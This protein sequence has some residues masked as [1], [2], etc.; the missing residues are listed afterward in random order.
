MVIARI[1]DWCQ[2]VWTASGG[3]T[4]PTLLLKT[5]GPETLASTDFMET[6]RSA[7][8]V[9]KELEDQLE[10]PPFMRVYIAGGLR[11]DYAAKIRREP[12]A[13]GE[14]FQVWSERIFGSKKYGLV[15]NNCELL[16]ER[17]AQRFAELYFPRIRNTMPV[18][19]VDIVFFAGN[20][21]YTPFGI[22]K[23]GASQPIL[24]FHLGP[25]S[26]EFYCWDPFAFE[27]LTGSSESCF[28]PERY[29]RSQNSY[30]FERG[31][32]FVM[33][34]GLYHI[35][36]NPGLSVTLTLGFAALSEEELL[37]KALARATRRLAIARCDSAN[38]YCKEC[39][40]AEAQ[41]LSM[42][43]WIEE[44]LSDYRLSL[45]SNCYFPHASG[46]LGC[47]FPVNPEIRIVVNRPFE[48]RHREG[49]RGSCVVYVRGHRINLHY[50]PV[51]LPLIERLNS[52]EP[53]LLAEVQ[54]FGGTPSS[55]SE[56]RHLVR[57]LWGFGG[58]VRVPEPSISLQNLRSYRQR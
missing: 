40:A 29:C 46:S 31:S 27:K 48:L 5:F 52:G 17:L 55:Q 13:P 33:P 11:L 41:R 34:G 22:H 4:R 25:H 7:S 30:L 38:A 14:A 21:G 23:D 47:G 16:N 10:D 58:V 3:F 2:K 49:L 26:K 50:D 6:L 56:L 24:H 57:H 54:E 53:M 39:A 32:V 28:Q 12:P 43:Q 8:T 9:P 19:L 44:A 42:D 20:Y 36:N 1:N 15:I 51:L 45:E 35:G 37:S 18:C